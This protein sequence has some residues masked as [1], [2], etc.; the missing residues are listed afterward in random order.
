M[1]EPITPA[2]PVEEAPAAVTPE[3]DNI[4]ERVNR[5]IAEAPPAPEPVPSDDRFSSRNIDQI[6]DPAARKFA[7][8]AYKSFQ[9]D[10]TRKMQEIASLRKDLESS[11]QPPEQVQPW[12]PERIKTLL[13]DPAF[14]Q[15]AQQ[16]TNESNG[17]LTDDE[18]SAL[19]PSEK[20]KLTNDSNTLNSVVNELHSIKTQAEDEKL[21]QKYAAYKPETINQFQSDLLSGKYRA[22]REDIYK[23]VNYED[24]I[25]QA[26]ELGHKDR[27]LNIHEKQN[28]ATIPT[29]AS[30][31]SPD[32][33][34]EK[35]PKENTVDFFKRLAMRRIQE[36]NRQ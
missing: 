8:D 30:I 23:V 24:A 21:S 25:K 31:Q 5:N 6:T 2:T 18:W 14:V 10:Y 32:V 26:Y 7:E 34:P 28:G 36:R 17:Q 27:Q 33:I 19:T 11:K 1:T 35:Q 15:S 20:Q 13:N 22:T 12:T 9:G 16:V 29:N 4:V 3:P